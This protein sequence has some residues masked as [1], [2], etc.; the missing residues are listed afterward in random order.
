[1]ALIGIFNSVVYEGIN[2]FPASNGSYIPDMR[3]YNKIGILDTDDFILQF[4]SCEKLLNIMQNTDLV[5]ENMFYDSKNAEVNVDFMRPNILAFDSDYI[6]TS[7]DKTIELY[8]NDYLDDGQTNG[9]KINNQDINFTF[10]Q[11]MIGEYKFLVNNK[12]VG[13]FYTHLFSEDGDIVDVYNN[14]VLGIPLIYKI[15][16]EYLGV[17]FGVSDDMNYASCLLI[18]DLQGNCI[19]MYVDNNESSFSRLNNQPS[20]IMAKC[21]S[22][23]KGLY[24]VC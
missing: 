11:N 16:K 21:L 19:D 4:I 18:F 9:I 1:M 3:K 23:K 7:R 12:Q 20:A 10:E 2:H 6:Y 22:L 13:W 14:A 17:V 8:S 15:N 5:F 24:T